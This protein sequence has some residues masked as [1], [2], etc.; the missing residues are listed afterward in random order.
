MGMKN[1][2]G[3]VLVVGAGIS[4]MR[5]A[6]DLAEVGHC[7]TLIDKA[8][9]H[10]GLLS[11]LDHQFP[12][13]HCGMCR[14]L[15]L[16]ERDESSQY[17]LRKGLFHRNIH[18]M[19]QTELVSLEGEPGKFKA[20]LRY[21]PPLVDVNRCIGCGECA[22]VCP[23]EVPDDFNAGLGLR[24]AI[25]NPL[26]HAEPV[27]Y[28]VDT[29]ACT[30]CGACEKACPTAAIDL[31]LES[32]KGFRILVVDDELIVRDSIKEWL[33]DE[34]FSVDMAG[35]GL[36][37]LEKLASESFQ[38]MLLDV[39]MPGID[40]VEVLRR[41]REISADL[42]VVMMTAYATV[43]SAVEAMKIG[44]LDYL[45][46]PFDPQQ[47]V[48][49]VTDLHQASMP[50]AEKQLEVGAVVLSAGFELF[51][52][53]AGDNLYG[54]GKL[55]GVLTALEFERFLSH[56][57]PTGGRLL[58]PSDGREARRI[59]WLQCVGSRN[60]QENADYCSSICCMFSIKEAVLA[61][62]FTGGAVDAT[63]FYMDLRT[64]GKDYHRYRAAAE[65]E[66]GVRFVRSR[67]HTVQIDPKTRDLIIGY[68]SPDGTTHHEAFDMVVLATGARPAESTETL[69]EITGFQRNDLGFCTTNGSAPCETSRKGV[70]A[71]GAFA[72][73]C[74]IA[75]SIIRSGAASLSSSLL[76]QSRT[77][78]ESGTGQGGSI[79]LRDVSREPPRLSVA[80]CRCRGR[81]DETLSP[82]LLDEDLKKV[83]PH[84][85]VIPCDQV[86]SQEGF[87]TLVAA[88]REDGANRVLVA[89]CAS[90]V[91]AG[92]RKALGQ[93]LGLDES[94]VET[95]DVSRALFP[96]EDAERSRTAVDLAARIR[97]TGARLCR[98]VPDLP[99]NREIHQRA[100]V[101]GGGIAGITAALAI[102]DHGYEVDLVESSGELG[103][104]LRD[105][106]RN[107]AG[108]SPAEIL[109]K[110][111]ARV[112]DHPHIRVHLH[113]R[114]VQSRGEVGQFRTV[115]QSEDGTATLVHHGVTLLATG[116]REAETTAYGYGQSDAVL[117][118]RELEQ[119]LHAGSVD[120]A[121][122]KLVAMIQCVDSR[123]EPRNYCSRICCASALKNALYLKERNPDLE[124]VILYRDM[125][126]YGFLE[127]YFTEARRAGVIFIQYSVDDK[128]R[129]HLEGGELCL[130]ARDPI[131][132]RTVDL[133]PDLLVLSTGIVPSDHAGLGEIFG[134][135]V[136][137]DGFFQ[138]A[139]PKW[140]PVDFI[141][142]GVFMCGIAHSPRSV[143]DSMA[144]AQAAA[145]RGLRILSREKIAAGHVVAQV[146]HSL[147]S[148][149]ERCVAACPYGAR[150]LDEEGEKIVVSE[151]MCQGCGACAAACPNSAAVLRGHRDQEVFAVIDAALDEI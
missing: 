37:A 60:I 75:E 103:G 119:K 9:T 145:M 22:R 82:A 7:V 62:N 78:G 56:S 20:L 85:R 33:L 135:E 23:V 84:G 111:L 101:V 118:Q 5:S 65:T 132:D 14:M 87:D 77:A 17:C 126:S 32:R 48:K 95:V 117:T 63:I 122:L 15:P 125:M 148:L 26:P 13:D 11:R 131:L 43:E 6:L 121:G 141:R 16:V 10:G 91:S 102:A 107:L 47:M 136:N 96:L 88:L 4:G 3:S 45:M 104:N 99:G 64:F 113:A 12:N 50:P 116:G 70:F 67:V 89:A 35:S 92:S 46:K 51:R 81:T 146:R 24:K 31:Q 41:S 140:R 69:A 36:E 19:F 54:Y 73:P 115:L 8:P 128:P 147:C 34:G 129:F 124:I 110:S 49:M 74:D 130:L 150:W 144:S 58:R 30:R 137:G 59:A 112:A 108:G 40:G 93:A 143:E 80:L 61:R 57:G 83:S 27:R 66:A 52:P 28:V 86:C 133:R 71:A 127:H 98:A 72:G 55:P 123:E 44:A 68:T 1:I 106:H 109:Q 76:L 21:A 38:L 18:W 39:K 97:M 151:L 25:Y 42:P 114:V 134:V 79:S 53:A 2:K 105:L 100:L 149:C 139:D 120:P 29:D 94:F 142:E 90:Q 138:E